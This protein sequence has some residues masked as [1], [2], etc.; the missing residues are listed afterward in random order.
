MQSA[1]GREDQESSWPLAHATPK[2]YNHGTA[3]DF[4]VPRPGSLGNHLVSVLAKLLR[5]SKFAG[6]TLVM[7]KSSVI[8]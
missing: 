3:T 1:Y 8:H 4:F 6:Q 2:S 5:Y 7:S